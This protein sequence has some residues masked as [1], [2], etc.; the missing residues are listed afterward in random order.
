[1]LKTRLPSPALVVACV[2]LAVALGGAGYAAVTLPPNSV[3]SKQVK[4]NSL[5]GE[6]VLE[7]SFKGLVFGNGKVLTNTRP[8]AAGSSYTTLIAV[9][10]V[11][12]I[13][14]DCAPGAVSSNQRFF[15]TTG[16]SA[17]TWMNVGAGHAPFQN[18]GPSS[19][20]SPAST[21]GLNPSDLATWYIRS[22]TS[23][24]KTT[25]IHVATMLDDPTS[26]EHHAVAEVVSG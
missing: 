22:L 17:L 3:G 2:A 20:G 23:S 26:C 21:G 7:S 4:P 25:I 19:P 10:G 8:V 11:G 16:Q 14:V 9:P 6:D 13:E 12:R 18:V 24:L 15:N 1:M 5:K